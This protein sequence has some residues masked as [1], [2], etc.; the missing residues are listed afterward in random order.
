[1]AQPSDQQTAPCHFHNSAVP[2]CAKHTN[3][4]PGRSILQD[5]DHII[6]L[7]SHLTRHLPVRCCEI[8]HFISSRS[9]HLS[10]YVNVP[11][12][13]FRTQSSATIYAPV[14]VYVAMGDKEC[15]YCSL[16]QNPFLPHAC[17]AQR[18]GYLA[19]TRLGSLV[20][21][22]PC[23]LPRMLTPPDAAPDSVSSRSETG[24]ER[25]RSAPNSPNDLSLPPCPVHAAD[26]CHG[27]PQQL[28]L[29]GIWAGACA[30]AG[31]PV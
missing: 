2:P 9:L 19:L 11:M 18:Q 14:S 20:Q 7:L 31:V 4:Q 1:M 28:A 22:T 12:Q 13:V 5:G 17:H 26:L 21:A 16:A 6:Y 29:G 10:G 27:L 15:H 25:P 8:R 3:Y 24:T 30:W 23:L